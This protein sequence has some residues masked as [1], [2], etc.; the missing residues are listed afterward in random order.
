MTIA[1]FQHASRT[2]RRLMSVRRRRRK[3]TAY[4][5]SVTG[6]SLGNLEKKGTSFKNILTSETSDVEQNLLIYLLKVH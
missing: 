5:R 2:S 6:F 3:S 4:F 1:I